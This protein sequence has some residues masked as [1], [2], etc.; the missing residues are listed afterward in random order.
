V[1]CHA[2]WPL[3]VLLNCAQQ[4][5][6]DLQRKPWSTSSAN[7]SVCPPYL[8]GIAQAALEAEAAAAAPGPERSL[9]PAS[10][11]DTLDAAGSP[12]VMGGGSSE[13]DGDGPV[14]LAAV[15]EL[16]AGTEAAGLGDSDDDIP[17]AGTTAGQLLQQLRAPATDP[18]RLSVGQ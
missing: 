13:V 6:Q 9:S 7:G 10:N 18:A 16:A 17:A 12:A 2:S 5:A 1:C 15:A 3:V 4:V 11:L 14:Q 8:E